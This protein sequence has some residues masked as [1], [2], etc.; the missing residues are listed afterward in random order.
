MNNLDLVAVLSILSVVGSALLLI[1]VGFK[2][3]AQIFSGD[4]SVA[5]SKEKRH[6]KR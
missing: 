1:V 2:I 6:E 5:D 4:R 3:R